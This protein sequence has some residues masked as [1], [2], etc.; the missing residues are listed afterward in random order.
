VSDDPTV[1]PWE[2]TDPYVPDGTGEV[3]EESACAS[4]GEI[5]CDDDLT[6]TV[7]PPALRPWS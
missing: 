5:G 4:W 1:E 7:P 2:S 3:V 6:I